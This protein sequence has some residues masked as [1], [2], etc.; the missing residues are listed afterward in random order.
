MQKP[1]KKRKNGSA[2]PLG[3]KTDGLRLGAKPDFDRNFME[4]RRINRK[5]YPGSRNRGIGRTG[6]YL[7]SWGMNSSL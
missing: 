5:K 4:K 7:N 1:A 2:P 3:R 6:N